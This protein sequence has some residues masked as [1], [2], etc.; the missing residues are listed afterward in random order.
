MKTV[1]VV[2]ARAGS[3]GLKNK[4][5]RRIDGKMVVEY[6]I[7]YSCA[8]GQD[9]FTVVSTDIAELIDHCR[10]NGINCIERD[11]ALCAYDSH[12][13]GVLADAIEK[14]G[15]DADYCSVVYGNVPTRYPVLFHSAVKFLDEN[16]G[17]DAVITMQNVEKYHP[18]FM[19][20]YTEGPLPH[21]LE[22]HYLRQAL[23][24][25]IISDG[26]TLIFRARPFY[27]RYKGMRPYEKY[28]YAIF[29]SAIKPLIN[30]EVIFDIDT[31]RD[32]RLAEAFI[33]QGMV[34]T[35]LPSSKGGI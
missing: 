20:D 27:E 32:L 5:I 28:R 26:H 2:C 29:G 14:I 19:Y 22:S 30:G 10:R 16:A 17:Y 35:G 33:L 21:L 12:I 34:N 13:T 24:Q 9:V 4:C 6:S 15:K 25:K 18:D 23:K 7:E 31:E 1:S 8:L 3:Q 11:K